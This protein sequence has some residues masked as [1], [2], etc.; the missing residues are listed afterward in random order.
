MSMH[1]VRGSFSIRKT[2]LGCV[3]S[4]FF[5]LL[6]KVEHHFFCD[7]SVWRGREGADNECPAQAARRGLGKG[8]RAA[9][10]RS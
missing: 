10:V 7:F 5:V 1:I 4:L 6:A 8:T 9:R 2:L 3:L